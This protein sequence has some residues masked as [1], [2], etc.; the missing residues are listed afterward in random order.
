MREPAGCGLCRVRVT[1]QPGSLGLTRLR[2]STVTR[3]KTRRHAKDASPA[4]PKG[5]T[6]RPFFKDE[7]PS[8]IEALG[9][10]LDRALDALV[11][12]GWLPEEHEGAAR[13]CLEEALVNAIRHG[14]CCDPQRRV[15]LE[16]AQEG[17]RCLIRVYDEGSGFQPERI[18]MPDAH[19]PGGRGICLMRHYMDYIRYDR[20]SKCLEMAFR[21]GNCA[22]GG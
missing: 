1:L 20:T 10:V 19:S 3:G 8:T 4:T 16:L 9:P 18:R 15:R 5:R 22:A 13:L 6:Q 17:E 14:N 12:H 11:R 21:R 2:N 7:F